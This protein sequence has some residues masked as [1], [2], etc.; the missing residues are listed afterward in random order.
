MPL[1]MTR[2]LLA[3]MRPMARV[4]SP[5]RVS[6]RLVRAALAVV[7]TR[8]ATA[9]S[10]AAPS[11]VTAVRLALEGDMQAFVL[12]ALLLAPPAYP[13]KITKAL[14]EIRASFARNGTKGKA[15][16][17]SVATRVMA[18]RILWRGQERR[19]VRSDSVRTARSP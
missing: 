19:V 11:V 15:D 10:A 3:S 2:P 5:S 16:G 1:T 12:F 9:K 7:S 6:D 8:R 17:L 13:P 14:S 18:R 4:K